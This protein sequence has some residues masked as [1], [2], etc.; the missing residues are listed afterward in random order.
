MILQVGAD[1]GQVDAHRDAVPRQLVGRA[2]A[3]EHQQLR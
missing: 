3:R 1:A 2:D